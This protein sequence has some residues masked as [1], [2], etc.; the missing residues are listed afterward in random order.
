MFA[1]AGGGCV[2]LPR[3]RS[4]S[5]CRGCAAERSAP[6]CARLR[7]AAAERRRAERTLAAAAAAPLPRL[8][9][10]R[11]AATRERRCDAVSRALRALR[12]HRAC[13]PAASRPAA[14]AAATRAASPP[15]PAKLR[16][17][18]A[19]AAREAAR[20]ALSSRR[21]WRMFS[22]LFALHAGAAQR[23]PARQRCSAAGAAMRA[24]LAL[25]ALC[26]AALSPRAQVSAF[27]QK[28][29]SLLLMYR[30]YSDPL[31]VCNDG[32]PGA[33][34]RA[35]GPRAGTWLTRLRSLPCVTQPAS[36]SVPPTTRRRATCGWSTWR[37]ASGATT[38]RAALSAR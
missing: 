13:A 5:R 4:G 16:A 3:R 1:P 12:A 26:L 23:V 28:T 6:A 9:P 35:A 15:T 37:A 29:G 10:S 14:A 18:A 24:P 34:L 33:R 2:P 19:Q 17:A 22:L 31:A 27:E 20:S 11:R 30:V 7:V 21:P 32:S 25:L 8:P 36:T 38:R